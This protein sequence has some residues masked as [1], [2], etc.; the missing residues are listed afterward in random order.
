M[1][2]LDIQEARNL[3]QRLKSFQSVGMHLLIALAE[4]VICINVLE[5]LEAL[6][7]DSDRALDDGAVFEGVD[8]AG[9]HFLDALA[10][11]WTRTVARNTFAVQ[12][13]LLR[14]T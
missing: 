13:F 2:A 10:S 12:R 1:I 14:R 9:V 7:E 5:A 11:F 4:R 8:I 6:I 3:L